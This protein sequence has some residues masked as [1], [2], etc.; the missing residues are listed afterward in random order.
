[1]AVAAAALSALLAALG[2]ESGTEPARLPSGAHP[3]SS[4]ALPSLCPAG[5]L[6]DHGVCIPVPP[7]EATSPARGSRWSLYETLPKLPDRPADYARYRYPMKVPTSGPRLLDTAGD[8]R[9]AG[10]AIAADPG[11]AVSAI[12]IAG[13]VGPGTVLYA[14]PLI[15]A[16]VITRHAVTEHG[17]AQQYLI[18]DGDLG[19]VA[20]GVR[21]GATVAAGAPLG[22]IGGGAHLY[23]EVRRL[24]QG[25]DA[26][27]LSVKAL[28]D[29]AHSIACDARNVLPVR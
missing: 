15:G 21:A 1:M 9:H 18:V 7:T 12:A 27:K 3:A 5:T 22:S 16:T 4:S 13:Q 11:A 25:V 19:H 2:S 20:A 24:R 17:R 28:L 8:A 6:P 26:S 23:L 29:D 10:L 14:G